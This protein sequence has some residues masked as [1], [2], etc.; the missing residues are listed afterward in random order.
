MEA[1]EK[2]MKTTTKLRGH[3]FSLFQLNHDD[4]SGLGVWG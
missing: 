4:Q 1:F 2:F 3:V